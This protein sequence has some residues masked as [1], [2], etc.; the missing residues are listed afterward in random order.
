MSAAG[1][2][3][4]KQ[5]KN[6]Y[7]EDRVISS[8]SDFVGKTLLE[9]QLREKYDVNIVSIVRGKTVINL[10]SRHTVLYPADKIT[11]VGSDESVTEVKSHVEMEDEM[12]KTI[13]HREPMDL[14]SL[15]ITEKHPF[16][17]K[18]I[19]EADIRN[20]YQ[21]LVIAIE[22]NDDH[23]MNPESSEIMCTDDTLWLVCEESNA[24]NIMS[25]SEPKSAE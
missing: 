17:G 15:Q 4:E 25:L 23:L 24:K 2:L 6:F 1:L 10:P 8:D 21:A 12:I 22:R 18:S 5:A 19:N 16:N 14:Y 13:K 3:P 9:L 11:I 20:K 7:L